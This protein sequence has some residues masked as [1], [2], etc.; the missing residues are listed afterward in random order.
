MS[1]NAFDSRLA[2]FEMKIEM[3]ATEVEE[4]VGDVFLATYKRLLDECRQFK[5]AELYLLKLQVG[6]RKDGGILK[7]AHD[8]FVEHLKPQY[9]TPYLFFVER[10]FVSLI[11][12]FELFLQDVMSIVILI[13]PKKVGQVEFKLSEILDASGTNELVRRGIDATLN[14]LM[15]KKP[16]E[17][18]AEVASLLSIDLAPL[19]EKWPTFVE[20]KARRD[21][22]V[23]NGWKC[24]QIYIRKVSEVGLPS[25]YVDG[26]SA[27][28][29]EREY[30]NGVGGA[31]MELAELVATAVLEKHSASFLM[32][33][34]MTS[35]HL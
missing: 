10:S 6:A 18:L 27:F 25:T 29:V 14:K 12:A 7:E 8:E 20:A 34:S 31:L 21:L 35:N 17:Y 24:N 1:C 3:E 13:N 22:G 19:E 32:A 11:S 2:R 15:Y 30:L 33:A 26:Q 23:H 4:T 16:K 9:A 5:A 28:P